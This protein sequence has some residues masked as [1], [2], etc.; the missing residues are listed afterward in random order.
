MCAQLNDTELHD[1]FR[2]LSLPAILTYSREKK[3]RGPSW[4]SKNNEP[5]ETLV[6]DPQLLIFFIVSRA[7]GDV[8]RWLA[9]QFKLKDIFSF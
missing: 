3:E 6:E 2:G 7:E 1:A 9:Q 8:F 4:L 5:V